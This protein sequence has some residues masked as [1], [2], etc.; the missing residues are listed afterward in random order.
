MNMRPVILGICL[1]LTAG[2]LAGGYILAGYWLILPVLLAMT[3]LWLITK[4]QSAFWSASSLLLIYMFLAAIGIMLDLSLPLL[5][6]GGAAA[7][8]SWDLIHF[9]ESLVKTSSEP[10]TQALS[11]HRLRSLGIASATGLTLAWISSSINLEL[12]FGVTLLLILVTAGSL[13]FGLRYLIK[14]H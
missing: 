12:S 10:S 7:L 9:E 3:F 6:I 4:N 13:V 1:A 8:A 2:C 11:S 14:N 5:T